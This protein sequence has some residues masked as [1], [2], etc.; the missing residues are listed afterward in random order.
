MRLFQ[1][2]IIAISVSL[3]MLTSCANPPDY[4]DTP[5]IEFVSLSKNT[6]LQTRFGS[7]T[8][9]LTFSFTDG[10]GDIS[11]S[12]TTANIFIVDA[13]DNFS[14][15]SYRIPRID[16]QGVGNGISGTIS[17]SVPTTCCIYP[18]NTAPPCDTSSFAPE[19]LD[20]LTYRI[21]I[22]DRARNMSNEI[23][24]QPIYLVCKRG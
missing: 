11:F 22:M 19:I 16:E 8:V 2:A 5:A 10:D 20:T 24:T 9:A 14:K 23:I 12:D 3:L 21:Q 18:P 4:S 17:I 6:M 1:T 15:P 7:D 13:R